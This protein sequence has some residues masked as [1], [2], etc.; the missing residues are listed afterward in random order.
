MSV[1]LAAPF[2]LNRIRHGFAVSALQHSELVTNL[3]VP[4]HISRPRIKIHIYEKF[5]H[6]KDIP[7]LFGSMFS[8]ISL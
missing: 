6:H 4:L 7:A 1:I 2:F 8:M 3:P 5:V